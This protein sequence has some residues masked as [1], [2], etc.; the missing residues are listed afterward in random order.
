MLGRAI[1]RCLVILFANTADELGGL[2][3]YPTGAELVGCLLSEG[4][5]VPTNQQIPGWSGKLLTQ[6]KHRI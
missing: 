1:S 2:L 5:F 4:I 3:L 6:S